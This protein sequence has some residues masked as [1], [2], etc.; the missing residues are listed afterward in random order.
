VGCYNTAFVLKQISQALS[1]PVKPFEMT[2]DKALRNWHKK[3]F[4]EM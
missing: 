4:T 2:K 1:Q 3:R